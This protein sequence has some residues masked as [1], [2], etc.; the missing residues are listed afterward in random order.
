MIRFKIKLSL[1]KY[2]K[3]FMQAKKTNELVYG[4]DANIQIQ[5]V[6]K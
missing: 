2:I 1:L 5:K 4:N 3:Y 6:C